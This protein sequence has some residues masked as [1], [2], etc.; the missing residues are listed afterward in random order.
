MAQKAVFGP[1]LQS[2]SSKGQEENAEKSEWN[3]VDDDEEAQADEERERKEEEEEDEEQRRRK[4]VS[5]DGG[6]MGENGTRRGNT[7]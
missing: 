7:V 5:A 4:V 3:E 1:S 2:H 6:D